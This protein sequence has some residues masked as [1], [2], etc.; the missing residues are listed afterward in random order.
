M[1]VGLVMVHGKRRQYRTGTRFGDITRL[2]YGS[3]ELPAKVR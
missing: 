1:Y 3:L 2:G